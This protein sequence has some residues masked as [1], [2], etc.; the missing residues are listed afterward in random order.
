[1]LE[2]E[3]VD[4]LCMDF[5]S[6]VYLPTLQR[7][8]ERSGGYGYAREIVSI[9]DDIK[10]A[11][12]AEDV[13]VVTNAGGFDPHACAGAIAT[14]VEDSEIDVFSVT[15]DDVLEDVQ[16]GEV[17]DASFENSDTGE[18]F[19][20]I[21][22]E[23]VAANAYLGAFPIADAL[24]GGA[25]IVVMGRA[26][27]PSLVVGP[28]IHEFDWG[29]TD[30]D[31]LAGGTVAGHLME[32]GAY[33]TGGRFM[34]GWR[35]VD[36]ETV[37]YPIADVRPDGTFVLTKPDG[38][39]GV[40][41]ERTVKE[42]LVYEIGDPTQYK[43]PDVTVDLT[44]VRLAERGADRVEVT[45]ARGKKRPAELKVGVLYRDGYRMEVMEI[46]SWPD[47]LEKART[48]R[49]AMAAFAEDKLD[50]I[51]TDLVGHDS[52]H[53]G[54]A[55]EPEDP[56]E[57]VL[58]FAAHD[59]DEDR[60]ERVTWNARLSVAGPPSATMLT[61]S[62]PTEVFSFWPTR[63]PRDRIAPV[64]APVEPGGTHT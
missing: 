19:D 40:V 29:P 33:V 54:L 23:I 10:N 21:D 38:T 58:R 27:D 43:T 15:G 16:R 39:G 35:D 32:C 31:R 18:S 9:V 44:S 5:L 3:D 26:A 20:A 14:A 56:A 1:M 50:E 42:Q 59:A 24:D 47:A 53:D 62:E 7:N 36:F 12:A 4:Y 61:S 49:R 60:L 8:S 22:G 13:T 25:D 45:G 46:Y 2:K 41:S 48:E 6:D 11:I 57:I 55:A 34:H 64:A 17:G 37:G 28:L 52:L 63:I 30:Y 51:R